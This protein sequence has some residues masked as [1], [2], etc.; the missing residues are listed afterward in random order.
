M[1]TILAGD[2]SKPKLLLVHGFCGSAA[3]WTTVMKGLAENFY[4]IAIDLIG[5]GT[6]SRPAWECCNGDEAD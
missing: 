5:M 6:S 1:T 2:P 3:F 4:I